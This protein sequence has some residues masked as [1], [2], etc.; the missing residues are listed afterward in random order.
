VVEVAPPK[1]T[2]NLTEGTK[3]NELRV[4]GE[5]EPLRRLDE[6]HNS[7]GSGRTD[8]NWSEVFRKHWSGD[9]A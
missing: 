6:Q 7:L 8:R 5:V 1:G 2:S 9:R 3:R 4:K